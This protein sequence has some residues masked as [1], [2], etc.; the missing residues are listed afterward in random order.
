MQNRIGKNTLAPS[1]SFIGD[2]TSKNIASMMH[3]LSESDG[4]GI[5]GGRESQ[6]S[7]YSSD[8]EN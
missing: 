1:V 3:R 5:R 7:Q 6:I 2:D 8:E 4:S